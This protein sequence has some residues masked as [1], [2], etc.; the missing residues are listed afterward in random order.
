MT[1]RSTINTTHSP[2]KHLKPTQSAFQGYLNNRL[3]A[4]N[5]DGAAFKLAAAAGAVHPALKGVASEEDA[6]LVASLDEG[7]ASEQPGCGKGMRFSV[8]ATAPDQ[9]SAEEVAGAFEAAAA[10]P[11][12][13]M[14]AVQ[15]G[16]GQQV[17]VLGWVG[18]FV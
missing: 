4:D 13:V 18:L 16:T 14:D 11:A 7:P 6:D 3:G 17:G 1:R 15:T 9:A 2:T 10:D 12:G 8:F 5:A